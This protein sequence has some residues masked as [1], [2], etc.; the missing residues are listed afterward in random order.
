METQEALWEETITSFLRLLKYE[1]I[2]LLSKNAAFALVQVPSKTD[3]DDWITVVFYWLYNF[4]VALVVPPSP[5]FPP[6]LNSDWEKI[7]MV[8]K[9]YGL[10]TGLWNGNI[11]KKKRDNLIWFRPG[12]NWRPSACK[13]DVITTTLRNLTH[14]SQGKINNVFLPAHHW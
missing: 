13:A 8:S 11:L 7:V 1:T 5:V 14:V 10:D 12:S 9:P 6:G 3:T 2:A 4:R